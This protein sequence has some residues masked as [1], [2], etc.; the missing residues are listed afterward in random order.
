MGFSMKAQL[1]G[2]GGITVNLNFTGKKKVYYAEL[3]YRHKCA[4]Y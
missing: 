4:P 1:H 2:V 3:G